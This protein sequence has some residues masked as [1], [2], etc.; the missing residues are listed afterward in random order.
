[1]QPSWLPTAGAGHSTPLPLPV[2]EYRMAQS[3]RIAVIAGDGIGQEVVPE[4]LRILD[5]L[6]EQSN[7]AFSFAYEHFPW[8]C[9]HYLQTGRMMDT[10]GLERL[11]GFDAIYFGAVGWPGVPDHVSLWGL[12]LAICQGFDQYA[13]VRPV[14]LLPGVASPLRAATVD[15]MDWVVVRENSEGEYAGIGGREPPA[16][17][18]WQK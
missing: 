7:G 16:R 13:N 17:S 6:A 18:P 14:R 2:I 4:G 5:R 12:R 8:G 1:M 10:D 11:R 15:T 9:Q 3:F